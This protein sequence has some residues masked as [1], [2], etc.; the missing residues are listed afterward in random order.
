MKKEIIFILFLIPLFLT[1][2]LTSATLITHIKGP[3]S[4]GIGTI[5]MIDEYG[6]FYLMKREI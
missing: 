3:T 6:E 2:P 1:I 5:A 4:D